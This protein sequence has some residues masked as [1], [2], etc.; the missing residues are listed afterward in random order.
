M[1]IGYDEM[2][3]HARLKDWVH[4]DTFTTALRS[5]VQVQPNTAAHISVKKAPSCSIDLRASG[6]NKQSQRAMFTADGGPRL[7]EPALRLTC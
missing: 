2:A 5:R 4:V 3:Q 1:L 7:S 6:A